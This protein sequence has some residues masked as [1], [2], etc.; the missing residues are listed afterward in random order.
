MVGPLVHLLG[1]KKVSVTGNPTASENHFFFA[2]LESTV[3]YMIFKLFAEHN[4]NDA[5]TVYVISKMHNLCRVLA[6]G[7]R[8]SNA[9]FAIPANQTL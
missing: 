5:G 7:K 8:V 6:T 2:F 9:L 1:D 3:F 4:N